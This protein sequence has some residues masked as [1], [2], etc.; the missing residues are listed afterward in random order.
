MV[1]RKRFGQH[2]LRAPE[3]IERII[4][5]VEPTSRDHI[6]EIG[7][8]Q[9]ALTIPLLKRGFRVDAIEIDRDLA[10]NLRALE[11]DTDRLRVFCDDALEFDFAALAGEDKMRVIGNLPYNISTPLLFRLMSFQSCIR[12]MHFMFQ[13]EVAQGLTAF[14]GE[15]NYSRLSVMAACCFETDLL[16]DVPA[17]AFHPPP[18]VVSSFVRMVPRAAVSPHELSRLDDIV[19]RAFSKR[20]KSIVN[21]L[22][23]LFD[24]VSLRRM[25][26]DPASRPDAVS[27]A[28]YL[29][30]VKCLQ[31]QA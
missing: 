11:E 4:G 1:I 18:A 10:A 6:I 31:P 7:S 9:G 23:P 15:E 19:K 20:R 17:D 24:E 21:A 13:R 5:V 29:R 22:A 16:F 27:A 14:A 8:G 12:D 30:M 28:E 25:G 3:F 26:I 2:F